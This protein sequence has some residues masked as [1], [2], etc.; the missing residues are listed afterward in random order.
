MASNDL[1]V[2]FLTVNK[3]PEKWAAYHKKVLLEAIKDRPLITVSKEPM[4]DLPGINI[5]QEEEPSYSNIYLS[6]LKAARLA[7][8]PYVA[9]AEDD[10]LYHHSHYDK[11]RP[12]MDT[13]AYNRTRWSLFTW[14]EPTYNMRDRI[15]NCSFIGPTKLTIEALEERFDKYPEGTPHRRTGELGK[16]RLDKMLGLTIRKRMDFNT[17]TPVIQFNHDYGTDES[18]VSHRKAMGPIRAYDLPHWGHARD[19]LANFE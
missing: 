1:T 2:M 14:R 13:F 18:M 15:S 5:I 4:P 16:E 10:T 9:M 7:E 17:V 11:F 19:L 3:V 12:P 8:T 6:M